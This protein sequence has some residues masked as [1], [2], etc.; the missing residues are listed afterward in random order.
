MTFSLRG[1]SI[2]ND[3]T[4]R[5]ILTDI[6]NTNVICRSESATSEVGDWFL[7]PTQMST[8][9]GDPN[10]NNDNGDRIASP[11]VDRGWNR[12]RATD[13]DGHQLLRLRRRSDTAE[14]GVF[15]CH[16]PEDDNTPRYLGIY[17]PSELY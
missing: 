3:G 4:G 13:S 5:V 1:E 9:A 8:N 10:D 11:P 17:Y 12:N 15:T 6:G 16:I 2:P 7:H 14:E